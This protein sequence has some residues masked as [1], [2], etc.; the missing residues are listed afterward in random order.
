MA[1]WPYIPVPVM[2]GEMLSAQGALLTVRVI[3]REHV[4]F[5]DKG[6]IHYTLH[7]YFAIM[8]YN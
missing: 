7:T 4:T 8:S 1:T 5:I 6:S 3:M 2:R